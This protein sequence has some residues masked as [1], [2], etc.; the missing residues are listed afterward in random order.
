MSKRMDNQSSVSE[1]LLLEF[2]AVREL[3]I[4]HFFLFLVLYLAILA[5]NLLIISAVAFDKHLHTPMYFFL[6]NLA[7]QDLGSV[8]AIIPKSMANSF[9]SAR[10]ISYSGCIVQVFFFVFFVGSDFFLLTVMAYDR[11]VAICNPLRYEM[12]MN[13]KACTQMV[14]SVWITGLLYSVLHTGGTFAVPFCSNIINQ[15]YCEIPHLLQ[16][17]CSNS[18]LAEVG[19]LVFS[20]IIELGC[21]IFIIL[22]YVLIFTAVLRM[23]SVQGR[24]KAFSTCL[25]HLIVFSTFI[26][27]GWFAYLR[28][29]SDTP[30]DLDLALTVIYTLIPP[31]MN[32]VIYSM[33]N[34]EIK[35]ALAKL[36]ACICSSKSISFTLCM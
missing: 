16:L 21:F 27:T 15:F 20:A 23:P 13:R 17:S 12:V 22:T 28:P 7:M 30:S 24:Q 32:P 2:S 31:M 10:H 3:Q 19:A 34:K 33:R 8:S 9:I 1:F 6:T 36:F 18:Y 5:G 4:L 35:V 14:A 29:P 25:P 11:Y 26:F